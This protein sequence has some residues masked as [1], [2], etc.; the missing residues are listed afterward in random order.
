[1]ADWEVMAILGFGVEY[2]ILFYIHF[3][4]AAR[5][6]RSRKLPEETGAL[7]PSRTMSMLASFCFLSEERP[8]FSLQVEIVVVVVEVVVAQ[9]R[10]CNS[11]VPPC[12][13]P[14]GDDE[15][16]N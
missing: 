7:K 12:R 8:S 1:M 5:T 11:A 13:R 16:D 14:A 6:T 4:P 9:T 2:S 15:R 10:R 3:F